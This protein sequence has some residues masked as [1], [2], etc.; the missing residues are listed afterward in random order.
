MD[1]DYLGIQY[2]MRKKEYKTG[3]F[4]CIIECSFKSLFHK[5]LSIVNIYASKKEGSKANETSL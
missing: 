2:I 3:Y 1:R 4:K 5:I